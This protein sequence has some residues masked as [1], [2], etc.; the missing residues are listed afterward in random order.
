[1]RKGI[2]RGQWRVVER[3]REGGAGIIAT[4]LAAERHG[5]S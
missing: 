4:H 5:L 2:A 3:V 1:M